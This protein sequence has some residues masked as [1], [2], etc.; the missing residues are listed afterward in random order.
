[1]TRSNG[2]GDHASAVKKCRTADGLVGWWA[3]RHCRAPRIEAFYRSSL[4]RA[5]SV[6]N[7][8]LGDID[9]EGVYRDELFEEAQ[10]VNDVEQGVLRLVLDQ[11]RVKK[12]LLSGRHL[13]SFIMAGRSS[14]IR[15]KGFV[16]QGRPEFDTLLKDVQ[17]DCTAKDASSAEN[18]SELKV[19]VFPRA[20]AA[21]TLA[22]K[23]VC[24][25]CE[26]SDC[27]RAGERAQ[28]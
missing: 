12:T 16:L 6:S 11:Q 4:P 8:Q 20:P 9:D 27:S 3:G 10:S 2:Q 22:F 1:M 23:Q 21:V 26:T 14:V 18:Y 25:N 7:G 5:P 24:I 28:Q 19:G 13:W 17:A 15:A